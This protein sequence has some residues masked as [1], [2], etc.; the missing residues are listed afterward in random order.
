MFDKLDRR[1]ESFELYN[2]LRQYSYANISKLNANNAD[3][4]LPFSVVPVRSTSGCASLFS[5]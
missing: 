2:Y 4:G 1:R 5:P 3:I